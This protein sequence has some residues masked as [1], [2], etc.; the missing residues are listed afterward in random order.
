MV[1]FTLPARRK[2][3]CTWLI[4]IDYSHPP[5]LRSTHALVLWHFCPTVLEPLCQLRV[6]ERSPW[7]TLPLTRCWKNS[8]WRAHR[9]EPPYHQMGKSSTSQRDEAILSS[10][11]IQQPIRSQPRLRLGNECGAW[12][13]A[14]MED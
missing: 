11:S 2:A 14:R 6:T 8:R 3:K 12:R 10:S 4:P 13:A 9:W 7:S 5:T 1:R